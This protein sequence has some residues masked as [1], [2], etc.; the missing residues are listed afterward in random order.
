MYFC[1]QCPLDVVS[2]YVLRLTTGSTYIVID[3]G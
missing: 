1:S 2:V 3:F